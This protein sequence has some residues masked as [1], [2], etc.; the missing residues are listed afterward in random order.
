MTETH[1]HADYLSGTR[2]LATKVGAPMYLSDEGGPDWTYG[3][4]PTSTVGYE[5]T[6]SWW[7]TYLDNQPDA[8]AYFDRM[9]EDNRERSGLLPDSGELKEFTAGE[10]TQALNDDRVVFVDTRFHTEVHSGTVEGALN[11]P[12]VD[13][14]ASYASWVYDR[15]T[16]AINEK[17][18]EKYEATSCCNCGATGCGQ[19]RGVLHH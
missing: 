9:K 11:V 7:G 8:H 15:I 18:K 2:E 6:F 12:G 3:A 10:L 13:K 5:R 16:V 17:L 1:I 19:S 4:I 14:A